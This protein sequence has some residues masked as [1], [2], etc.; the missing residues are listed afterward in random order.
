ML[1]G[2]LF[3]GWKWSAGMMRK[4]KPSERI[5]ELAHEALEIDQGA[6]G[7]EWMTLSIGHYVTAIQRYLDEQAAPKDTYGWCA[8]HD[9]AKTLMSEPPQCSECFNG[10]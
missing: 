1:S 8:K 4:M 6:K 2:G 10:R 3:G 5:R 9:C 7:L